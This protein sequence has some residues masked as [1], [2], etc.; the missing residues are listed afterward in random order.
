MSDLYMKFTAAG[1]MLIQRRIPSDYEGFTEIKQYIEK[2]DARFFN[3]ETTIG[4]GDFF[5]NQY[6]GGSYLMAPPAVLDDAKSFGFNMLSF[7]NNHSMDFSHDGL[8]ST[9]KAVDEAG[10][11]NAGAGANLDEAAAPAYLDTKNGRVALISVVSTM[12]NGAAMAGRQSRRFKGR[13]GVNGLR[14]DEHIEVTPRQF[15][16]LNEIIE[17]SNINAEYNIV[18]A[19]GYLPP[20]REG[21]A[22]LKDRIFN[23][24]DE[25]KYVA[26]PNQADTERVLKAIY[27]SQM[28][29]DYILVSVH[30][31]EL[32]GN[33][34]ENPADFLCEFAHK[35][36]DA[37]AHAVI[38]HGPHL[39]RP[40]EIYKKRPIF[41]SLGD[42]VIHNECIPCAPYEM[43]ESQNL[44]D[45]M[46]MRELFYTRSK[47]Y[48]R[49][50]MRDRRMLESFVPYFEMEDGELKYLELMPIELNFDKKGTW[51]KGDPRFSDKHGIIERLAEMSEKFGTKI[52][53][54]EKGFGIVEIR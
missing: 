45:D 30:S 47:G 27:E 19:E 41:Y 33:S 3:L 6:C 53:V 8:M 34:K 15:E 52:T 29:A 40:I 10:F 7:A 5:A 51:Q 54:N 50:L 46:T 23:L 35:C 25:T 32:S 17:Q 24:G 20:V 28:Q 12:M 39:I 4:E 26:R 22:V 48:T 44:T 2:G 16:V 1:D 49:G 14:I 11:P 13:P 38:G 18:R 31:H 43:Y 42:F 21:S 37:G 9:K 36:I